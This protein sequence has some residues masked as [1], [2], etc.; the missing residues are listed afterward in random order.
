MV[1]VQLVF[2]GIH[3]NDNV[4]AIVGRLQKPAQFLFIQPGPALGYSR[5]RSVHGHHTE[6][7]CID[8][9]NKQLG[10]H[11]FPVIPASSSIRF[12]VVIGNPTMFVWQPVSRSTNGSLS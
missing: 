1:R 9:R 4:F 5:C 10:F 6:N 11:R 3:V 8:G 12:V 2:S 7:Y